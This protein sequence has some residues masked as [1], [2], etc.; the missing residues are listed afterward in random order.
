MYADPHEFKPERWLQGD[1][2]AEKVSAAC[3]RISLSKWGKALEAG[4]GFLPFGGGLAL[5]PGRRFA[6]N[7]M[8]CL[9]A[10]IFTKLDIQVVS[11]SVPSTGPGMDGSRAGLG[12]FPPKADIRAIL[13]PARQL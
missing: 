12:I 8:K 7:E 10:Q 11:S 3:G 4:T 5:C 2:D 6:R 13:T 1:S 9:I